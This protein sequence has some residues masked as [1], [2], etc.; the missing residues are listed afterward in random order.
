MK[1]AK[2]LLFLKDG[3]ISDGDMAREVLES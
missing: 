3:Q 1:R 2:K